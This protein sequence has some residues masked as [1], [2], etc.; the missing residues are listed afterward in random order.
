MMCAGII[1]LTLVH[2]GFFVA[3]L[4]QVGPSFIEHQVPEP[5][6]MCRG[7]NKLPGGNSGGAPLGGRFSGQLLYLTHS[8]GIVGLLTVPTR[9]QLCGRKRL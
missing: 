3:P 7:I 1:F 6:G 4:L 9:E 2:T 8:K 5:R